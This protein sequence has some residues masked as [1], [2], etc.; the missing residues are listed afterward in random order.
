MHVTYGL[1][2]LESNVHR[3]P[4]ASSIIELLS[5][6]IISVFGEVRNGT[7]C[8]TSSPTIFVVTDGN[9]PDYFLC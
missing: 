9:V 2:N 6:N 7:L 8:K 5:G 1:I 3:I 4:R